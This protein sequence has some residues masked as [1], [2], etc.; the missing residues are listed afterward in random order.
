MG[1]VRFGSHPDTVHVNDDDDDDE[2][3]DFVY[4]LQLHH[5]YLHVIK[6]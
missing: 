1:S 4:L 6:T 2:Y 5:L 3:L